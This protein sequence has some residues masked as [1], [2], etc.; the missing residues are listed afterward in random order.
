MA[1]INKNRIRCPICKKGILHAEDDLEVEDTDIVTWKTTIK[2][3]PNGTMSCDFCSF[4]DE[5]GEYKNGK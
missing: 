3:F 4:V 5:T 2:K 1:S